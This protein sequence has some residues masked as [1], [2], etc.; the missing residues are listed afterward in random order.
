MMEEKKGFKRTELGSFPID[1]S[2]KD[3][4][5]CTSKITDGTHDTPKKIKEGIPYITA[6]HVKQ[7]NIDFD[8]CYYLPEEVH[9]QIFNRCNPSK[10]D[11]LMVNIGA[12]VG[13]TAVVNVHFEFSLKNVALIKPEHAKLSGEYLNYCLDYFKELIVN[14]L[15]SGGAQGFLSL[16]KISNI[17]IPL[18][19]TLTEQQAIASALSDVDE[20]IRS[21]DGLIQKKQAIKKGTMQQLLTGKKRLPGF[22]GEWEVKKLG[23]LFEKI[24]GGGTPSRSKS[25]Y[26]NGEIPWATV[27]DFRTFRETGTQETITKEGLVNSSSNLIPK[28]TVITSTRM[29]LGQAVIYDVDVA[30]NQDLKAIFTNK[31]LHPEYLYYWFAANKEE[32]ESLGSGSTVKGISLGDLKSFETLITDSIE[33]QKA[34]AQILS[35]MD[36]ELQTL[37][38]K[39]EKYV[40]IK[41]GMMQELLTGKTRLV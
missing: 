36:R 13:T 34:I 2:I 23:E 22:D 35:D 16:A 28:G 21:L 31:Q 12:G 40:Q 11:V 39:R 37:R 5:S 4:G 18:P 33:E 20:L 8:S 29:G 26:W 15:S 1:W 24:V 14:S 7:N 41:Q 25:E 32:I 30:I 27:K 38:Q 17:K 3:L 6:I 19:P 9:R 10:G